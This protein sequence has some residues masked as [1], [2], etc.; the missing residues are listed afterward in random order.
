MISSLE[1]SINII[2]LLIIV[3]VSVLAGFAVRHRQLTRKDNRIA[4]LEREMIQ[5]HAELLDT[6]KE[7]CEMEL[8]MR[9]LTIP[10]ISIKQAPKEE[11]EKKEQMSGR[12]GL[13]K[14]LPNRTA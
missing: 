5:A 11:D 2:T 8:R 12:K 3:C 13:R 4:E 9:D 14:D 10:V 6:Q 7:Y 1:F